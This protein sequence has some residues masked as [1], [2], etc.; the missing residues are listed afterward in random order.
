MMRLHFR[1]RALRSLADLDPLSIQKKL[2]K[3]KGVEINR[4]I[5]DRLADGTT[6]SLI[7]TITDPSNNNIAQLHHTLLGLPKV[8]VNIMDQN[9]KESA[10]SIMNA[11]DIRKFEIN[12]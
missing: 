12:K 9:G 1:I 6:L 10:I 3:L 5:D 8:T 11:D 7:I 2:A 4:V